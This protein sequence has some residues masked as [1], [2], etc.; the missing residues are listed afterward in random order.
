MEQRRALLYFNNC[1]SNS[2]VKR[3]GIGIG[4]GIVSVKKSDFSRFFF[5]SLNPR[6]RD[7]SRFFFSSLNPRKRDFRA[8]SSRH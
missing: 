4:I 8:F 6:K 5:S 2:H 1:I 3:I 7:F